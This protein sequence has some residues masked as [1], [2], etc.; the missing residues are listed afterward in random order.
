MVAG[1]RYK[2]ILASGSP[3]RKALLSGLGIEFEVRLLPDIDESFPEGL[4]AGE[5]PCFIAREKADAYKPSLQADE[6]LI[7]ADTIVWLDGE[8]L[9]KPLDEADARRILHKLSGKT[10]QVITGVCLTTTVWQR[11]FNAVTDVT[12]STL[13][14]AEIDYYIGN[15]HPFD[16][17]GAYGVQE[18]IGYVAVERI[19]GSFYNVMGLPIQKLY[20]ELQQ[21]Q[22]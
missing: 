15:Y 16:K 1:I 8:V 17:A 7:T 2:I 4:A 20:K 3:R 18:W 19:E 12:F 10:H 9:G 22:H 21:I 11:T 14:D 13:T 5:I 6:L